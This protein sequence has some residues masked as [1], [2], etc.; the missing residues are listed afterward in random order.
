MAPEALRQRPRRG[1][2]GRW[3]DT[4]VHDVHRKIRMLVSGDSSVALGLGSLLPASADEVLGGLRELA[5]WDFEPGT[6]RAGSPSSHPMPSWSK[7]GA[8]R[9]VCISRANVASACFS[10]P[11]I[12]PARSSFIRDWR[13]SCKKRE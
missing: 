6:G 12:R 1:P 13:R 3:I 7:R 2:G 4:Q 9:N 8:S 5:D 10:V 11:D